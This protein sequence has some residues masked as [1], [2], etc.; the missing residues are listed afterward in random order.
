MSDDA[1]YDADGDEIVDGGK[2]SNLVKDLRKQLKDAKKASDEA[3]LLIAEINRE[4][5]TK[6]VAETLAAKG[7]RPELAKFYTG[8]DAS[9]DTIAAWVDENAELF[10]IEIVSDEDAED[11]RNAEIISR[12]SANAPAVRI[13][14]A[15]DQ[16]HLTKS[17]STKELIERGILAPR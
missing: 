13:G 17:L 11:R 6:T 5:R 8:E 1:E 15:E 14:S 16:L 10:G 7:A 12:A 9:P 4:K 3:A 2:D